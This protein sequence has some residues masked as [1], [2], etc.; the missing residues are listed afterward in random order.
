MDGPRGGA[1]L[2]S[3]IPYL[4]ILV[5]IHPSVQGSQMLVKAIT[6]HK[7]S[8]QHARQRNHDDCEGEE[9]DVFEVEQNLQT[10]IG[11]RTITFDSKT[12]HLFTMSQELRRRRLLLA[13][14]GGRR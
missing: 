12:G 5:D 8:V 13:V 2:L 9:P 10:M 6:T 4:V 7:A 3:P 14:V 11:A 1:E